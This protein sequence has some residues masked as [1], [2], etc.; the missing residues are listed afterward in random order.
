MKTV[1]FLYYHL[2]AILKHREPWILMATAVVLVFVFKD[3]TFPSVDNTRVGVVTYDSYR[4]DAV[5][6]GLKSRSGVYQV[7]VYD[8][9]YS[10]RR[11]VQ[12]GELECGFIFDE[13]FDQKAD[14]GRLNGSI[15]YV[16]SPY[17]TKGLVAKE[18]LFAS[19]LQNYSNDILAKNYSKMFGNQDESLKGEIMELLSDRNAYYIDSNDI[20]EV[21]FRQ[22]TDK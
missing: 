6:E 18:A 17:T 9:P 3:I 8:D 13:E 4:A 20:F 10:L 22:E 5:A 2:K 1:R 16:Y 21:D 7:T 14:R 11:D 19:F 12:K 15:E